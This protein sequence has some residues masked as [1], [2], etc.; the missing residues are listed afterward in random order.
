MN[1]EVRQ[2]NL[3]KSISLVRAIVREWYQ[4]EECDLI[5]INLSGKER[6]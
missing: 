1:E 4:K 6:R 2:T 5:C 3:N